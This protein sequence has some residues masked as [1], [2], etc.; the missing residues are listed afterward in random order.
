MSGTVAFVCV[1]R[2]RG[3]PKRAVPRARLL[4]DHGIEGDSHAGP[5]HRQVS[6]LDAADIEDMRARGLALEPGA[7]GENLGVRDLDLGLL[8]V[9]SRLA[10]GDAELEVTQVGKTCHTRCAIYV[11]AGDCI[12]PRLGLFA[13]VVRGG[14]VAEGATVEV[15]AAVGRDALQFGVVTV[16]D[17]CAAGAARD[18][19]GPAV[20]ELLTE[21]LAAHRAFSAVVPDERD[22]IAATLADLADRDLALVITVGGTG[23]APRDVTPE[24]TRQVISREVP[25]L[26]EAMRAASATVTPNAW[27]SRAVCGV[28]R[29]TLIVNLPGSRKAA[30]ENLEAILPALPHA[31]ATLRGDASHPATDAGRETSRDSAPEACT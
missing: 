22:A 13:R 27:L 15:L 6:L 7:F 31:V 8:G 1:S 28:R 17:R 23:L 9:G 25:G 3:V 10:V 11:R 2:R 18:T 16:S 19:A 12:M 14:E 24:A 29:R 4:T 20:G 5:W 21:R 30:T 26:A